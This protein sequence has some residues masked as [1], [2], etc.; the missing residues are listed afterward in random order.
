M[1]VTKEQLATLSTDELRQ[2]I[3]WAESCVDERIEKRKKELWGNVC[4]AIKK[5]ETEVGPIEIFCR[6]C[7][8]ATELDN[9]DTPGKIVV[10]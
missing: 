5:Y 7:G 1:N 3:D 2:V 9:L 4:G 10:T 8:E 6:V